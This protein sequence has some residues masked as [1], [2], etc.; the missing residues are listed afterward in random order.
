MRHRS[1]KIHLGR[2]PTHRKE[3]V[4]QL[5]TSLFLHEKI[6]TTLAKAKALRPYAERLI[7]LA[8]EDSVSAR[9]KADTKL[10]HKNAIK[11]LFEV[12][13]PKYKER[14]G[15]YTSIRRT[16]TRAGDS[17]QKAVISLI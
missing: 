11:K 5:A 2:K 7:T 1:S 10:S 12:I 14:K 9:R 3:L 8:S 4:S 13:G 6:E 15:G 17:G 16:G